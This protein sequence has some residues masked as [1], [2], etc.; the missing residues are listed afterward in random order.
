MD[1]IRDFTSKTKDEIRQSLL[2][3]RNTLADRPRLSRVIADKVLK[4]V[5]GNVLI[6]IAIGSEVETR[7][8]ADK[9]FSAC[10]VTLFAPYTEKDKITPK[11]LLSYG[12]ADRMGN[13]PSE[14]Y[15][16]DEIPSKIDFVLTPLLGFNER[17]H[18]IGYGKGCYDRFF[19]DCSAY[20]IGLAFSGQQIKFEPDPTDVPLDCCVTD[21]DVLYF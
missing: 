17:G 20:K 8:I 4:M 14:C 19:A 7:C 21:K 6:Y 9:L 5:Q 15:D 11:R 2:Q 1:D 16:K 10:G 13:L 18:R 3:Y 12:T